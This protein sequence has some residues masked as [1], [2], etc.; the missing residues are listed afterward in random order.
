MRTPRFREVEEL[1]QGY[2]ANGWRSRAQS[3]LQSLA[4]IDLSACGMPVC[5]FDLMI[6]CHVPVEFRSFKNEMDE[7]FRHSLKKQ[8]KTWE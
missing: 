6:T 4:G 8:N 1:S 7:V 3:I 2:S 5:L